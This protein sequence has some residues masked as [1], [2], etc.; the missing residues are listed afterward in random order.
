MNKFFKV[1][2]VSPGVD[3]LCVT[4]WLAFYLDDNMGTERDANLHQPVGKLEQTR[5][6]NLPSLHFP[7]LFPHGEL[8]WHVAVQ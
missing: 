8:G 1:R 5:D 3:S 4:R 2:L 7:L 6:A